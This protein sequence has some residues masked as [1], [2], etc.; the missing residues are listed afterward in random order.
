MFA[1]C[2]PI[3]TFKLEGDC[4]FMNYELAPGMGHKCT[5]KFNEEFD[6]KDELSGDNP[7]F[8]NKVIIHSK[9]SSRI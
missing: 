6:S 2:K 5:F 9:L 3:I 7:T 1:G 8:H 4:A